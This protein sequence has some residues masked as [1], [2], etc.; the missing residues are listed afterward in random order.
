MKK[1]Y[2]IIIALVAVAV[3]GYFLINNDS[4]NSQ[5]LVPN[6]SGGGNSFESSSSVVVVNI[7]ASRWEY[8]PNTIIVKKGDHV[9][10]VVN[11]IDTNH[12]I[13]IPDYGI[14]GTDE[15]SFIAN[16]AGTFSFS[17]PTFCGEGHRE[18]TGTLIV[19]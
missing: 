7:D 5:T 16:K 18:M 9:R 11:N 2:L 12:G 19:E 4:S 17:C 15:V 3:A 6:Q 13:S 1:G 8:S 14:S 10:I